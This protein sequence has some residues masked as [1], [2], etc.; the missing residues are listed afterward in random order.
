[1]VDRFGRRPLLL[2][3]RPVVGRTIYTSSPEV[4]LA[5]NFAMVGLNAIFMGVFLVA[6]AK[7][8]PSGVPV[9][10]AKGRCQ[11]PRTVLERGGG[12]KSK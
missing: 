5:G 1:M 8:V 11:E 4:C 9:E 10:I 2:I 3:G 12:Y 6:E 7:E